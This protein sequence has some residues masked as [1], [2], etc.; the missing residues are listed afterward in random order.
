MIAGPPPPVAPEDGAAAV[1]V[2]VR[3]PGG[4]AAAGR[5]ARVLARAVLDEP[6]AECFARAVVAAARRACRAGPAGVALTVSSS[7]PSVEARVRPAEGAG[8]RAAPGPPRAAGRRLLERARRRGLAVGVGP[9]G[10][11]RISAGGSLSPSATDVLAA[12]AAA[13]LLAAQ[14]DEA[15]RRAGGGGGPVLPRGLPDRIYPDLLRAQEHAVA[16][17]P[18]ATVGT[19]VAGLAHDLNTPLSSVTGHADLAQRDVEAAAAVLGAVQEGAVDGAAPDE[20]REQGLARLRRLG[21][22]LGRVRAAAERLRDAVRR[23]SDLARGASLAATAVDLAEEVERALALVPGPRLRGVRIDWER[24]PVPPVAAPSAM[25][26]QALLGLILEAL[27]ALD[28]EG[29]IVLA[30]RAEGRGAAVEVRHARRSPRRSPGGP[31]APCVP[32]IETWASALAR[33]VVQRHGGRFDS[34]AG[35]AEGWTRLWLPALRG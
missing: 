24:E 23:V 22:R 13:R 19:L 16:L 6:R 12:R 27:A 28:G 20:A 29:R 7:P 33:G 10:E 34:D 26:R 8:T 3:L 30:T 32:S 1:V 17:G 18:P 5:V 15:A 31:A 9:G 2:P 35:E 25:V 14:E 21:E 11:V 4:A